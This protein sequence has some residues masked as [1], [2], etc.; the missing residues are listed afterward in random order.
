MRHASLALVIIASL[1][2]VPGGANATGDGF[3][4]QSLNGSYVGTFSGKINVGGTL[5]PI[6][7]TG[8]FVADGRGHLSGH[9]TYTIDTTVCYSSISGTYAINRDGT[10]KDSVKFTP[11]ASEANC[12]GG[13]YTQSFAIGDQGRTVLLSNTNGDRINEEWYRQR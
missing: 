12:A 11:P 1:T 5:V 6:L 3:S 4:M 10:G 7:G 2:L 13:R 9:E 8:L